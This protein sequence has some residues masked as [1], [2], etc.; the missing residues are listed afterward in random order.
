M[1]PALAA[2][3]GIGL[4]RLWQEYREKG[5]FAM[6]LP[7][8][9]IVTAIWQIYIQANSIGW[10]T[11]WIDWQGWMHAGLIAGV[12]TGSAGMLLLVSRRIPVRTFRTLGGVSLGLGAIALSV[13]PLAWG[14]S[15]VLP[16]VYGLL[17]SADLA[18][19]IPACRITEARAGHSLLQSSRDYRLAGF[20]KRNY[21]GE[22]FIL[23]TSTAQVAAPFIIGTGKAVM[24]RGGF[25]GLDPA[26]SPESL[27]RM[28]KSGEV[29]F[30]MLGDLGY[31][32]R[33][34]GG[35]EAGKPVFDWV[36]SH[37]RPV[38]SELWK[39]KRMR[40]EAELF[41]MRP[42]NGLKTRN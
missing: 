7:K 25:H 17:P 23:A 22:R 32:H 8:V 20:L 10:A 38:D 2:L 12:V 30:V 29:R 42:E 4:A 3:A 5:R 19:M 1:A 15:S 26:V 39:P 21:N 11:L 18:R 6:L 9:L 35:D 41:D 33:L 28:V 13:A 37:G 16:P 24:A 36:R 34:M 27:E 40:F 14:L 31:A